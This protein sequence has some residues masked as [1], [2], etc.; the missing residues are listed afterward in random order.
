MSN[1]TLVIIGALAIVAIA[2]VVFVGPSIS[3]NATYA[4]V[5][6]GDAPIHVVMPAGMVEPTGWVACIGL[7][8]RVAD[9]NEFCVQKGYGGLMPL[10]DRPCSYKTTSTSY[11]WDGGVT[12]GELSYLPTAQA[13]GEK[14][15]VAVKCVPA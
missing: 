5:S 11:G 9:L 13:H 14:A 3:G 2:A 8:D 10:E 12:N 6:L 4:S 15:L 1:K 7:E